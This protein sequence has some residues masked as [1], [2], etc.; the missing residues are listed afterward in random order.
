MSPELNDGTPAQK[1]TPV[2]QEGMKFCPHCGKQIDVECVVCPL[3]GKQVEDLKQEGAAMP[4]ITINNSSNSSNVNSNRNSAKA[5]AIA[6]GHA[7]RAI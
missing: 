1:Q 3:C 5:T 2:K 6:G 7:A 4:N